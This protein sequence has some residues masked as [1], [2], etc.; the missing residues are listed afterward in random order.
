[1]I[2]PGRSS[3][4]LAIVTPSDTRLVSFKAAQAAQRTQVRLLRRQPAGVLSAAGIGK[5][6]ARS[7]MFVVHAPTI[8][9]ER[10]GLHLSDHN[11]RMAVALCAAPLFSLTGP[12][13]S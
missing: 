3:V 9:I 6:G 11:R 7:W 8:E 10:Q 4:I 2:G 12:T 13:R 5:K 1:M